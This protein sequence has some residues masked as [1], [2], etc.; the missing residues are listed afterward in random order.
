M[1]SI[2]K[3]EKDLKQICQIKSTSDHARDKISLFGVILDCSDTNYDKYCFTKIKVVDQF[4][5]FT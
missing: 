1:D 3:Q 4:F 2:S 5:N